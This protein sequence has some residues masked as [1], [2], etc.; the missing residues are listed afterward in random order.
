MLL[1]GQVPQDQLEFDEE[2]EKTLRR[3]HGRRRREQPSLEKG[4]THT[5]ILIYL[6]QRTDK[7]SSW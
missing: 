6:L 2:I 4:T 5:K 3:N 7:R 1:R